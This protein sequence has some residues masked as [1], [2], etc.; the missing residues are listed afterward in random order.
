MDMILDDEEEFTSRELDIL[1][2]KELP[3]RISAD[4]RF[5]YLTEG[6]QWALTRLEKVIRFREGL[7][8]VEGPIGTGKTSLA[9]RLMELCLQKKSLA[10]VY[11]HT[12]RYP[13]QLAALHA[14][15]EAF[16]N[17]IRKTYV[18][19]MNDFE[20][21]LIKLR[22]DKKNPVLIID[23]AQYMG[24]EILRPIQDFLNFDI[25]SK[26][27]QCILFGQQ[28]IH[29]NFARNPALLDRVA[30]WH[31]IGPLDYS[32]VARMI[33]F[34]LTVAGR[35]KPIFNESALEM[36]YEFSQGIHRPLIIVCNETLHIL[37][38][39]GR[40]SAD[41]SD[42]ERA[43]EIYQARPPRIDYEQESYESG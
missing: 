33:Q 25:S 23:D 22:E 3:F 15:S 18:D 14:F 28:E 24:P 21:S 17:R 37:V 39:A 34:R 19:Q 1:H 31:K 26:M 10:P 27:I 4:S 8:V 2:L 38:E 12:P 36:L 20:R 11:I 16:R 30:F 40:E 9:R 41:A 43:I 35:E 32:E 29:G 42:V 13:T 5:L 7:A 6:H